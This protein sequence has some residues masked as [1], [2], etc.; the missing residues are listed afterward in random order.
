MIFFT[1]E[2]G[3]LSWN[4]PRFFAISFSFPINSHVG[5]TG[6]GPFSI[7]FSLLAQFHYILS[8]NYKTCNYS[9]WSHLR[10]LA[11]T[12]PEK[13]FLSQRTAWQH[14]HS[15]WLAS[16]RM[17]ANCSSCWT[18]EWSYHR[19]ECSCWTAADSSHSSNCILS[20]LS[21]KFKIQSY[22]AIE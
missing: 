9:Q 11:R 8:K 1:I 5:P 19:T 6:I 2:H 13:L 18:T 21:W 3:W 10:H 22:N 12:H 15:P 4:L 17:A 16:A 7:S 14:W 20:V